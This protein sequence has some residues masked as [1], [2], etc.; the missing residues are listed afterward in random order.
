MEIPTKSSQELEVIRSFRQEPLIG[1]PPRSLAAPHSY[2]L[3]SVKRC[4]RICFEESENRRR[5]E[6]RSRKVLIYSERHACIGRNRRPS[7]DHGAQMQ[8]ITTIRE[9]ICAGSLSG[10]H[11]GF[12][13]ARR[14]CGEVPVQD[15][16]HQDLYSLPRPTYRLYIPFSRPQQS[17]V[18]PQI[19]LSED[20]QTRQD[21]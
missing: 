21:S 4:M 5:S 14:K 20:T 8:T 11:G 3:G 18:R 1:H 6:P 19:T 12:R 16:I 2:R 17:W 9:R 10:M 7:F 13:H 15:I